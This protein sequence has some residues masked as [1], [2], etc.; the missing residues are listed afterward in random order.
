MVFMN[1]CSYFYKYLID[2]LLK[3]ICDF[4][5]LLFIFNFGGWIL[6]IYK[7]V[8]NSVNIINCMDLILMCFWEKIYV[9]IINENIEKKIYFLFLEIFYFLKII[10]NCYY[11]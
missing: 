7:I 10:Y 3:L 4:Y 11:L 8:N 1:F 5:F 6:N 2:K 9:L